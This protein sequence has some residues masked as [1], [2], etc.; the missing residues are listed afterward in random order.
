L[1]SNCII[2]SDNFVLNKVGISNY[3]NALSTNFEKTF[4]LV[5]DK[6]TGILLESKKFDTNASI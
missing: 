6:I 3:E 2:K 4:V 5:I 1:E